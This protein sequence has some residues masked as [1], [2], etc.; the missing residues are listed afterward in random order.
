M[1][2]D[3][4]A[5]PD[6]F[7]IDGPA[8]PALPDGF[9]V[10][11][12]PPMTLQDYG[13][14]VYGWQDYP[15]RATLLPMAEDRQGNMHFAMPQIGVDMLN[16]ALLPGFAAKG[17]QYTYGDTL[18]LAGMA[19][20]MSVAGRGGELTPALVRPG[21]KTVAPKIPTTAELKAAASS[22]YDT[23]R[24]MGV[25]YTSGSVKNMA[26]TIEQALNAEGRIGES[27]P[28]LFALL[29]KFKNP[30]EGSF[31]TLDSLEEFRKRLGDIAGSPDDA[32]AAAASIAKNKLDSFIESGTPEG[33]GSGGAMAGPA[34]TEAGLQTASG[35]PE[36][37]ARILKDA[38]GNSAAAFRA[39]NLAKLRDITD[40]RAAAANSGHNLGNTIRGR[41]ATFLSNDSNL[42]G[43]SS[44]EIA[45]LRQ[46]VEGTATTN[47]LRNVSNLLGGGGGLGASFLGL[48]GAGMG[49]MSGSMPLAVAGAALPV[50]GGT[51]RAIGNAV[52]KSQ[53]TTAEKMV[54]SRSPLYAQRAAGAA[55]VP[56]ANIGAETIRRLAL[57]KSLQGNTQ[58]TGA[59]IPDMQPVG[60]LD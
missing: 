2:A 17:G 49:A 43:F 25:T 1:A 11:N 48:T 32:K 40:L 41:L 7:V 4:I 52:T 39:Q 28:E 5:P 30:P 54:R 18:G 19:S 14:Q 27:N 37:A 10:D 55:S 51:L 26:D 50:A 53:L 36:E 12:P 45:A 58:N 8:S 33:I 31:V 16:S 57:L 3:S 23:A 56:T 21:T 35:N 9:V 47:T 59:V 13:K 42:S 29:G 44:E 15:N 22:A 24:D 34:A 60:L 46:I 20:P 38:R 6:G